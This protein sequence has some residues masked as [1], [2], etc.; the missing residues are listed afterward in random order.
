MSKVLIWGIGTI[1]KR[2]IANGLNAEIIGFIQSDQ[3]TEMHDD[4]K[5]FT[6]NDLPQEYDFIIVANSFATEIYHTCIKNGVPIEKIIFLR[7]I[8]KQEGFTDINVI[9]E[10][11]GVK[12]FTEYCN[13][14][15]LKEHSFFQEDM[16]KY[17]N[18]NKRE[19]F[20]IQ[21]KYYFPILYE[22]YAEAGEISNYFFQDLWAARM[23]VR[24]GIKE[25]F[26]IGSRID[27]FITHLLAAD[28]DVTMID[29]R[30]FPNEVENLHTIV[31]DDTTLR[32]IPDESIASMSALCSLEHFG[33]GRYGDKIDPDACYKCFYSIE[34]KVMAGGNIYISVPVGKEHIEFNAHRVFYASTI[35]NA[36]TQCELIEYSYTNNG[37]IEYNIDVHKYDDDITIGGTGFGLFHFTKKQS[38]Y[39]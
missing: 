33:L 27:G 39:K 8:K 38:E 7:S 12:N 35:I 24:S 15:G 18:L 36:F 34:R 21:E 26:D 5:V 3:N 23:I 28:I 20:R 31:D 17:N 13:E 14:F 32:Q 19:T 9:R 6:V 30:E 37:Y 25:H 11:L 1:A 29:V 22:K 4:K 16:Q 2:V 10:L